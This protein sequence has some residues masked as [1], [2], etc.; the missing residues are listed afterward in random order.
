MRGERDGGGIVLSALK[1]LNPAF[2]SDGGSDVEA[3]T[4]DIHVN[5]LTISI[6]T[7]YGPQESAKIDIKKSFWNYLEEAE[8][9]KKDGKGFVLQGDLNCW[10]G[11][12]ILP[13]DKHEQNQNGKL[14]DKFVKNNNLVI[15][16]TLPIC[17]GLVTRSRIMLSKVEE[18]TVDFFVVCNKLLPY[19]HENPQ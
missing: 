12:N 4:V 19:V 13:H 10:L 16:N 8:R 14:F 2:I 11:P 17:K 6:T 1:N 7:A 9:A 18:S 5:R 3:L 15:V